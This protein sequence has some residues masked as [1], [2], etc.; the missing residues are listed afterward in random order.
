MA[1][2]LFIILP[3]FLNKISDTKLFISVIITSL[4]SVLAI[5]IAAAIYKTKE[6]NIKKNH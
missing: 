1:L 4:V 6:Y 3:G 2:C 5:A